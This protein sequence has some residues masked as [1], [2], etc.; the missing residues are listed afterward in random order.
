MTDDN[1]GAT[2]QG[3]EDGSLEDRG[4]PARPSPR[5]HQKGKS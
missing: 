5:L 4:S 1:Q 2:V 3:D